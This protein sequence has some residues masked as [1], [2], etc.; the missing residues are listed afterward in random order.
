MTP[1]S[2][3]YLERRPRLLREF[4]RGARLIQ[5]VL[6]HYFPAE[7]SENLAIQAR[8]EYADLIPQLPDLGGKEPFTRFLIS[9]AELLAVY[10]TVTARDLS[11]AQTGELVFEI[12]RAYLKAYPA[13][14]TRWLGF[15][16]FTPFYLNRLRKR[17]VE[18]HERRYPDGYVFDYIPGDGATF[19]YGVDYL[20]CGSC[21]FLARQG[22]SEFA[23]YICPSDIL[24]SKALGWGLVRTMTLAEG[25]PKCDFRFKR[26]GPTRVAVP[27]SL[28]P[29]IEQYNTQ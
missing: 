3:I 11:L 2:N 20:E 27:E 7:A 8:R 10:R 14:M 18:S 29:V 23:P 5:P 26:G 6:A 28:R 17:A 12:G 24:Y 22:A 9:T 21:K 19:D 4:D 1:A 16:S 25:A 13:Y 15:M